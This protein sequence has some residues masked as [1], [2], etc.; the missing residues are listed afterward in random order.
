MRC[1][2]LDELAAETTVVAPQK[3]RR[4]DYVTATVLVVEDSPTTRMLLAKT[5]KGMGVSTREAE[6]GKVALAKLAAGDI[7]SMILMDKE[8]VSSM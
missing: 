7:Y 2:S 4:D 8:M 3:V 6:N 1:Q 5:L